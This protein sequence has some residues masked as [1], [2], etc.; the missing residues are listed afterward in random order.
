[1]E[2]TSIDRFNTRPL[3]SPDMVMKPERLGALHQTRISFVRTVIRKMMRE[4]WYIERTLFDLDAQGYG[5][6]IYTIKPPGEHYSLVIFSQ[7]L[8]DDERTDRVLAEKWDITCTLC[9]GPMSE[10]QLEALR[11]NVPKQEAGRNQTYAL[12]LARANKSMRNFGYV[13]NCLAQGEQPSPETLAKVGYLY[14]TTAVYGNGKFG[15]ADYDKVRLRAAF[16]TSFSAQLFTVYLLR[17]FSIEQAEHIARHKLPETAVTLNGDLSRYLGVG[18]ATGLGMV[19]FL[20]THPKLLH[21]W[22]ATREI[23]IARVLN[24][25]TITPDHV[26][27]AINL[28]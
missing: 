21:A 13:V 8:A 25:Q 7:P 10:T 15:I 14:R 5:S 27:K 22:V 9:E 24:A 2:K 6:C 16:P 26:E 12:V 28:N 4:N 18:N 23:A 3:R 1:M 20:V 11:A 17:R 19:P